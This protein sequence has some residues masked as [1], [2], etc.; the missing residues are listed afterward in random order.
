[1]FSV[2]TTPAGHFIT[3]FAV[4]ATL[5]IL[6]LNFLNSATL[7]SGSDNFAVKNPIPHRSSFDKNNGS[8]SRKRQPISREGPEIR[9]VVFAKVHKAASTTM[10]NIF[11]RFAFSRNLSL[12]LP[13]KKTSISEDTKIIAR[14]RVVPHPEGKK[15][16]DILCSHV[17]YDEKEISNYFPESAVRIAIVREPLKQALSALKYYVFFW[18]PSGALTKGYWGHKKDPING[19]LHHPEHFY[20]DKFGPS[21]SYINNRMSVDLGFDLEGMEAA[22]KNQTKIN[23]FIKKVE[24]QFD[25]VLVSDYFDESLVLMR[26]ILRWPMKDIIFLKS[27][28]GEETKPALRK[29]P[30]L[31]SS[32]LQKFRQ[33][34]MIDFQLYDHFLNIF[35]YTIA[36]EQRFQEELKAFRTIQMDLKYFCHHDTESSSLRI[37]KSA[38]TET[39]TV[40]RSDC[41]FM[42]TD[43]VHLTERARSL[44]QQRYSAYLARSTQSKPEKNK[45]ANK[46]AGSKST[47]V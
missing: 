32:I 42:T 33:W 18:D 16:Y 39:F 12:L 4:S 34:D 25:V 27:N 26:R 14:E 17:L 20:N 47:H 5:L 35:L 9:Q 2:P 3:I 24:A 31:N 1:M 30:L 21:T 19:F 36:R 23:A 46:V 44:Q 41:T 13:N 37:P 40:L 15:H 29:K 45:T 22:K 7:C 43:E 38:W 11:L 6:Y 8:H 28:V 10:Q